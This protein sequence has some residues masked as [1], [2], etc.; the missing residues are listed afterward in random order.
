MK[1]IEGIELCNFTEVVLD[2]RWQWVKLESGVWVQQARMGAWDRPVAHEKMCNMIKYYWFQRFYR[3][4]VSGTTINLLP[5]PVAEA[6]AEKINN[7]AKTF[8]GFI[9]CQ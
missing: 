5:D 1:L 2:Q 6:R 3:L 4:V 8:G 7:I 9:T